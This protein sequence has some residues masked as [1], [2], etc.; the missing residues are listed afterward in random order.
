MVTENTEKRR[1]YHGGERY[2]V[3]GFCHEWTPIKDRGISTNKAK[4]F[5]H[6]EKK[7]VS[8]RGAV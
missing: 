6:R 4:S 1:E 7:R 3:K 2:R 5:G 8:R